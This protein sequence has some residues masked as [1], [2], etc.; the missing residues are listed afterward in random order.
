[1][2]LGEKTSMVR[3]GVV[4][5]LDKDGLRDHAENVEGDEG[6]TPD[7]L[8]DPLISLANASEIALV[9]HNSASDN[10]HGSVVAGDEDLEPEVPF[11]HLVEYSLELLRVKLVDISV[12][13]LPFSAEDLPLGRV[14]V[15]ID[16]RA[17]ALPLKAEIRGPHNKVVE[18]IHHEQDRDPVHGHG[19]DSSV[20]ANGRVHKDS[21][22]EHCSVEDVHEPHVGSRLL[23]ELV[24]L[25]CGDVPENASEAN[26][27]EVIRD[28]D[29]GEEHEDILGGQVQNQEDDQDD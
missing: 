20:L 17:V 22:D 19:I 21:Y 11:H 6:L 8:V 13:V 5:S 24:A 28:K 25:G 16:N 12:F 26:E 14:S 7:G 23:G 1:M 18:G 9:V 29:H 15:K 3:N 2:I 4:H 10:L 27:V